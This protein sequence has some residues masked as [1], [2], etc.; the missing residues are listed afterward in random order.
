MSIISSTKADPAFVRNSV[1]A[2]VQIG[3]LFLIAAW[4]LKIVTPFIG[5][6]AWAAIIAVAI[7]PLHCKLAGAIGGRSKS[8]AIII[9]LIGLSILL[10]P[11]WSLTGSSIETAEKLAV[12]L[13]EGTLQ[14][15][16]PNEKV[17]EWPIIGKRVYGPWNEA[18]T[19]LEATLQKHARQVKTFSSWLFKTVADTAFGI[20]GFAFSIIIAG[21]LLLNAEAAYQAFRAI[22]RRL[23]GERGADFTD[24]AVATVRSVAKGVLGVALIQTFLAAV[25]L[26]VMDVP[27]AGIWASIILV[28]AIMQLP[29]LLVL[30]PVAIWVFST[31]EPVPA[32][33]FLVYALIVSFSDSFLKPLLLGRGVDVPML[34]ILL[35]AIGGMISSGIIGLFIGAIILALGYQLFRFWLDEDPVDP[36]VEIESENAS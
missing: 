9:V 1:A 12:S 31:A 28:L 26:L 30:G 27:G 6:I 15:P 17:K 13:E 16:P 29:P 24:L 35:G 33:V 11:T 2:A 25:G 19:N 32:T 3:L 4:C 14:V 20:L 22:G 36:E 23:G 8:S 7:Y 34:V 21:V 5:I 10:A 18:A